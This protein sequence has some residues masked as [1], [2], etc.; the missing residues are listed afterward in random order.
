M[1]DGSTGRVGLSL[2]K[3]DRHL[4]VNA[5]ARLTNFTPTNHN[6]HSYFRTKHSTWAI[7]VKTVFKQ[8]PVCYNKFSHGHGTL[9]I[10]VSKSINV[11]SPTLIV[12]L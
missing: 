8:Y 9:T 2:R 4:H 11:H 12:T 5:I 7:Y 1:D 3:I 10:F 6:N